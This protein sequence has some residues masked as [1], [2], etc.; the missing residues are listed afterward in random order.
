MVL[1]FADCTN[2]L[3]AMTN[4]LPKIYIQKATL[5]TRFWNQPGKKNQKSCSHKA[6]NYHKFVYKL[7]S[8]IQIVWN[9]TKSHLLTLGNKRFV[10]H[11][12]KGNY[13]SNI[14]RELQKAIWR[15]VK[16]DSRQVK[17]VH[18]ANSY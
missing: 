5:S 7:K 10:V 1:N 4:F 18:K 17:K 2:E 3:T 15:F 9:D 13:K 6:S 11:A 14:K 8:V 12:W 16:I